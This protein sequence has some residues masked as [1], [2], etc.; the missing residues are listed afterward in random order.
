MG[1]FLSNLSLIWDFL[2]GVLTNIF[3]LYVTVPVLVAVFAV[4]LVRKLAHIFKIF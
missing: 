2:Q 4:W 3:N 1:T